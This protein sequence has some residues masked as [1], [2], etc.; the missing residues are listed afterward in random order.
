MSYRKIVVRIVE[1]LQY[2]FR[3]DNFKTHFHWRSTCVLVVSRLIFRK[4][5][6]EKNEIYCH[7]T[8]DGFWIDDCIYWT[9]WYS[10]WL[11]FTIHYYTNTHTQT[12]VQSHVLSNRCS[13][14]AFQRWALGSW[15]IPR[16][17]YQL[18]ST[19]SH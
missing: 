8:T 15:T 12:T 18:L 3:W 10:A 19:D 9:L 7:A 6:V 16:L 5:V 1:P 4:K 13:V 17:S 14:A 2:L 11:H